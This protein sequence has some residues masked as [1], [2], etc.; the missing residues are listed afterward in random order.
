MSQNKSK[1]KDKTKETKNFLSLLKDNI[2]SEYESYERHN[3]R[4]IGGCNICEEIVQSYNK[5]YNELLPLLSGATV[6]NK[7]MLLKLIQI[8]VIENN[9]IGSSFFCQILQK[10]CYND[11]RKRF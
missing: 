9:T 8:N 10:A 7:K 11:L 5:K 6:K 3:A 4:S 2:P 1:I